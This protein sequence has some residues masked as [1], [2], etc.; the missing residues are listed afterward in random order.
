MT[1]DPQRSCG[2]ECSQDSNLCAN[3]L[4]EKG[5]VRSAD[6]AAAELVVRLDYGDDNGRE[7]I[8]STGFY[9]DPFY[10]PYGFYPR[11]NGQGRFMYG[12]YDPFLFGSGYSD[13]DSYT[14]YTSDI[15]RSEEQTTET[16]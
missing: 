2:L 7:K 13:I 10:G 6:P 14:V 12:Y 1:D 9:S 3:E 16:Q 15:T 5:Y 11:F 8:R 4:A